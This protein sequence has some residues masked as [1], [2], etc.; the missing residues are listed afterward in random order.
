MKKYLIL[1]PIFLL[2]LFQGSFLSL[3]LVLLTIIL[4]T[5]YIPPKD[6]L[7]IAF[8]SGLFLDLAKG[9]A[10]GFSSFALLITSLVLQVYS[11]RFDAYHPLFLFI[12]TILAAG[13]MNYIAEGV[14]AWSLA[15]ILA[16][17]MLFARVFLGRLWGEAETGIRLKV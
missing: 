10:L 17:I 15:L 1:L 7:I 6:S 12:F 9:T 8:L 4:L 2:V 11:H 14:F 5:I 3:N 13:L 16:L